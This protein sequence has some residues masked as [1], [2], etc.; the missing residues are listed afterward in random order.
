MHT[1][2]NGDGEEAMKKKISSFKILLESD[3]EAGGGH[4]Y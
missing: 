2:A 1:K 4:W 3:E